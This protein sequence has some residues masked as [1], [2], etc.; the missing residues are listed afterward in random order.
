QIS[1]SKTP[2]PASLPEPGG[3]FTFTY[4]VT[5]DSVE[6]VTL[7]S[8][9]DDVIGTITLP[10]DVTLAPGESS[11]AMTGTKTYTDAGTYPNVV[12]AKAVDNEGNEDTATDD[13][14]VTVTDELPDISVSKTPSPASLPEPGGLF[15]FTYVVTNDSVETV[16]LTS[17]TDDVIGT[18]TLPSDV[19]LSP[20]E[21]SDPMTGTK[22]YT[23]AGVYPN[24]VT[25]I[26][27]D[28]EGNEGTATD[29]ASVTVDDVL[30]KVS[31]TKVADPTVLPEPGGRFDYVIV[32][33]N[34]SVEA[35]T[36]SELTDTLPGG[37]VVYDLAAAGVVLPP[38]GTYTWKPFQTY[39]EAGFYTDE[40]HVI[41]YDNEENK[42]EA[43][44]TAT[45][46]VTDELPQISVSKTPSPAS[47][48]EPGGE[49]TFT[50]VVTNDSVETVTLT[51]V[52]D[53]V[54]GT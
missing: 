12:T 9:T 25:A 44:A 24:T 31:I 1:V 38:G 50:Y 32:V 39:T 2:S 19:T 43:R 52:T 34:D 15:T 37:A 16:T 3:E 10:S 42:A 36:L 35:I 4:V 27:Y 40:A 5:N 21:S 47:L 14:S 18:I 8:V 49:F 23:D 20:G 30:P 11:A 13:A 33:T 22:T 53:D 17:V 29:D 48:P 45:V 54:I 6:T 41:A 46:E 26:A 28:N 7:T 51:S